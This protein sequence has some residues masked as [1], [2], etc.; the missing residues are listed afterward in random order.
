MKNFKF[1]ALALASSLVF[2]AG[3]IAD[4]LTKPQ[5]KAQEKTIAAQYKKAKAECDSLAGNAKDICVAGAKGDKSVAE[6]DLEAR[7]KPGVKT[8]YE[9]RVAKADAAYSV[10]IQQCDEKTGNNKDVCA[11]EADAAK[12]HEISDAKAQMKTSKADADAIE[13]SS[14]ANVVAM[15]KATDAHKDAAADQLDSQYAVDKEKCSALSGDAKEQ[16]VIEAKARFGK[17]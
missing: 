10:A 12:I 13:K 9:A 1:S 2:S 6:A 15:G 8:H 16:C 4:T 3:A 5:Y 7:Y 11:K 14:D 17:H